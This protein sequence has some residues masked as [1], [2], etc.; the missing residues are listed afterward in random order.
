[1]TD[2]YFIMFSSD[3]YR[4]LYEKIFPVLDEFQ[5]RGSIFGRSKI[6][7]WPPYENLFTLNN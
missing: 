2:I 1:M 6:K 7:V 4:S 5:K 3:V